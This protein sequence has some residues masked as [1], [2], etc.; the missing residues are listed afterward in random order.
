MTKG[1][2]PARPGFVEK[3]SSALRAKGV[4]SALG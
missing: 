2:L 4:S 3:R 1:Q